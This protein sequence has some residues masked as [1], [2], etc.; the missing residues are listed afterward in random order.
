MVV[1]SESICLAKGHDGSHLS[2]P[3]EVV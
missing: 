2:Y 3:K 1:G